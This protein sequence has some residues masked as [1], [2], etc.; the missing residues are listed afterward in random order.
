MNNYK[1]F[2]VNVNGANVKIASGI[3]VTNLVLK[4]ERI[5]PG[6]ILGTRKVAGCEFFTRVYLSN[7]LYE[8]WNKTGYNITIY[9]ARLKN[10]LKTELISVHNA[11]T[12]RDFA[13]VLFRGMSRS[14]NNKSRVLAWGKNT[15]NYDILMLI[16]N[17]E[18]V[19]IGDYFIFF[20]GRQLKKLKEV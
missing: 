13:F 7:D 11:V 20:N 2:T 16:K 5:I 3:Q 17:D 18:A 19:K 9:S 4:R 15:A 14:I 12:K 1:T 6:L 8:L 10:S